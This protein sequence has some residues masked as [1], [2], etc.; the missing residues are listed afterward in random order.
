M[1]IRITKYVFEPSQIYNYQRV[2]FRFAGSGEVINQ[3]IKI[4][5]NLDEKVSTI[6]ERYRR[7]ANDIDLDEKFIFNAKSLNPD[8]TLIE[9]G[10]SYDSHI[11]VVS[12]KGVKKK[13]KNKE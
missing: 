6:F 2:I 13:E 8:F 7:W 1:S 12:T 3:S 9:A 10:I 5:C 4:E 11:F